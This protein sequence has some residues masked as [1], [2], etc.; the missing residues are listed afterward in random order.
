MEKCGYILLDNLIW[1]DLRIKKYSLEKLEKEDILSVGDRIDNELLIAKPIVKSKNK[2]NNYYIKRKIEGEL[3]TIHIYVAEKILGRK[4]F[5]DECVHHID[6]NRYN[7]YPDNLVVMLK[8]EH[9][10]CHKSLQNCV[11]ELYKQ[12]IVGFDRSIGRY[13]VIEK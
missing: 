10:L 13:F 7:N 4:L 3:R 12:D 5:R 1:F 6:G 11:A 8:K 9:I 2:R